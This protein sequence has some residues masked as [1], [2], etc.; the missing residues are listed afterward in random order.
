MSR[1]GAPDIRL[2]WSSVD[3][4]LEEEYPLVPPYSR[5]AELYDELGQSHFAVAVLPLVARAVERYRVPVR[6]VLDLACGTGAAAIR[7]ASQGYQVTAVDRSPHMLR[8]AREKARQAGV[9]VS[10]LRQSMTRLRPQ[11]SFDLVLC[12]YDSINHL[13]RVR[14]LEAAISRVA[15]ALDPGGLFVF[16][17]NTAHCLA[18]DWGNQVA[19][20]RSRSA[21]LTHLYRYDPRT[22]VGTLELVCLVHGKTGIQKF[23]ELHRE[24][25]YTRWEIAAA[26]SDGG[27]EILEELS[28][29][30]LA[31]PDE[32]ASRLI[33]VATRPRERPAGGQG[34]R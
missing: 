30:D 27:L 12:L 32:D 25:G 14:D 19:E 1:L 16:D 28:F 18:N 13:L 33:Y 17:V 4:A 22:R 15:A 2:E 24:R 29:P 6:R 9:E 34:Q 7:L 8:V 31:P 26:L 21:M 11:G 23:R 10:F 5:Y 20:E 3:A